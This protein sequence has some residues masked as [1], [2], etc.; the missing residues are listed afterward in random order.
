MSAS[1]LRYGPRP[2]Q[3]DN[4]PD[5]TEKAMVVS[6]HRR[7]IELRRIEPGKLNR[8]ANVESFNGKLR[9]ECLNERRFTFLNHA[10]RVIESWRRDH[11]AG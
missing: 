8:N 5:V 10:K 6:A 4:G 11:W 2:L 1:G 3:S 7:G 9:D